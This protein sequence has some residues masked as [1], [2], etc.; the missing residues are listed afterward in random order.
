MTI[1]QLSS[2]TAALAGFHTDHS[3]AANNRFPSPAFM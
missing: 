2:G 3:P 1:V